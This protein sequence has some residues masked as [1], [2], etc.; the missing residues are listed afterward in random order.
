VASLPDAI[1]REA[2]TLFHD[3]RLEEIDPVD[4]ADFV[5]SRV[6]DW[7]TMESVRSVVRLYGLERIRDFFLSGGAARVSARTRA[8][9][10]PYLGL[11]ERE[12]TPKSSPRIRSQ[13][14]TF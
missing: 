12:C 4:H 6:L 7:G 9:W 14:W 5:I 13:F 2:R 1:R 11:T 3:V 8:L 10:L